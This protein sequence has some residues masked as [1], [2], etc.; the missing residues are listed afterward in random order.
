MRSWG[1]DQPQTGRM[2][3]LPR[4]GAKRGATCLPSLASCGGSSNPPI[5]GMVS[6]R[7]VQGVGQRAKANCGVGRSR[8]RI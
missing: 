4:G 3:A 2:R 6:K 1:V 8:S 7:P 5:F